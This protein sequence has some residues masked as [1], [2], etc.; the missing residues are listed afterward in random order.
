MLNVCWYAFIIFQRDWRTLGVLHTSC[1]VGSRTSEVGSWTCEV[2]S[3][4]WEVQILYILQMLQMT[5]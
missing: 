2:G 3:R 4:T 5:F 1:E